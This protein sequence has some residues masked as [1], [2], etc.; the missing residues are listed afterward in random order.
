M[1]IK[2]ISMRIW[3]TFTIIISL[4]I[5]TLSLSLYATYYQLTLH[6]LK[7]D[8]NTIHNILIEKSFESKFRF[9]DLRNLKESGHFIVTED[10][11]ISISSPT[12]AS[13]PLD[14]KLQRLM[15]PS[16]KEKI[17]TYSQKNAQS[18]FFKEKIFGQTYIFYI[19]DIDTGYFISYMPVIINPQIFCGMFLLGLVFIFSGLL[20]SIM[21]SKSITKPLKELETFTDKIAKKDFSSTIN[22]NTDDEVGSLAKSMLK[23]QENLKRVDAEEKQFLQS[24]SHDLKTP[25]AVIL[26]HADS[27]IDGVYIDSVEQTAEIIKNEAINLDKKIKKLLYLNTLDFSLTNEETEKVNLKDLLYDMLSRFKFLNPNISWVLE[28][29]DYSILANYDKISISIENI[30]DNALRY[31][32]SAICIKLYKEQDNI[33]IEI[34]NDGEQI[35]PDAIDKIFN[36]LYKDKKGNFGLGLAISQKIIT[37]YNGVISAE[38]RFNGVSFVIKFKE[39]A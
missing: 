8:L 12:N 35:N 21:V 36:N 22:I 24:I 19:T 15:D 38:N 14:E 7:S 20:T 3:I 9:G 30:I 25:V 17:A 4:I 11:M 33:V 26:A 23:M 27:I 34:F 37:H 28:V 5:T 32:K 39:E 18:D 10:E 1:K 31:A 13:L 16:V 29:E 6:N 2:S